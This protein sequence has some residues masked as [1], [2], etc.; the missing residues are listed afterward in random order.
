MPSRSLLR[1][2]FGFM[3]L[4][5]FAFTVWASIQQPVWE[6]QGLTRGADR[7]WTLAT[8]V[9]AYY[10]F[11]TFYVWVWFKERG[12]VSRFVWFVAIMALGTMAMSTYV[13]LQLARL[14]PNEPVSAMLRPARRQ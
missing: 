11:I 14:R 10:G 1:S 12:S 2:L 8:L 4:S 3:L 9:D 5:L 6:W 13:L 7:W